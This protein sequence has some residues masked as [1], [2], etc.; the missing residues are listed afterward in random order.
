MRRVFALLFVVMSAAAPGMAQVQ[1]RP[2][3]QPIVT[4][5]NESWYQNSEAIEYAGDLYYPTGAR[6]FFNGNQMIR[7]GHYN[8]VPIYTDTT[9]EPYSVIYVPL[10]RGQMQPYERPRTGSLAG[11]TAS[12]TPAFPVS[13]TDSTSS[14]PQAGSAPTA[15]P[16]PNGA[17]GVYTPDRV[18]G[19]GGN[20]VPSAVGTG[21]V[22]PPPSRPQHSALVT[23]GHPAGNDGLWI[24]YL[25]ERWI[26]SGAAVPLSADD[27]RAVGSYSGFPVF[28]RRGTSEQVIYLPTRAGLI[29]PYKLKQ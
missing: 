25:G 9:L 3:D 15:L 16:V 1:S 21:G 27:F 28:A 23:I 20:V 7:S 26:S 2:T 11:T 4:A 13:E 24:S 18:A 19:T 5:D 17:I 22:A 6:V 29:A 10:S 8:G 14:L 12:R